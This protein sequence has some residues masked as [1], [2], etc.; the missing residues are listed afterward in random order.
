MNK[1]FNT[2][3]AH[4]LH[5]LKNGG[6]ILYPTDTVW[7]IGCDATDADAV[8]KVFSIKQ[9]EESKSLVVLVNNI[10]MLHDYVGHVPQK[11]L[12]I[13]SMPREKP[14]TIVYTDPI[15]LAANVIAQECTVAIRV[16]NHPFCEALIAALG[17][18]IVSTSA[19]ISNKSTP[20][21]F[22]EICPSILNAVD[23]VVNLPENKKYSEPSR[24]VKIG[25]SGEIKV[26]RA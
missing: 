1:T 10:T 22:S 15:N 16:V 2:E 24:I 7:G 9:R 3:L 13:L 12:E 25:A 4:A 14:V 20:K 19:N 21:S 26:I 5:C 6:T 11:A 18:P 17:K 8:R 23:Y